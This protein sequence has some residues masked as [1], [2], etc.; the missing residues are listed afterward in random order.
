MFASLQRPVL[1][2]LH[3]LIVRGSWDY[4]L[5][6][7]LDLAHPDSVDFNADMIPHDLQIDEARSRLKVVSLDGPFVGTIHLPHDRVVQRE[8]SPA[9]PHFRTIDELDSLLVH[10]VVTNEDGGF[11]R[12]HGFNTDAVKASIAANLRAGA[13][14]RGAG[15]ITMQLV[16]NLY[17]GHERTL[18]RKAQ[19][20]TLTW[21]LEHLTYTSKRRLLEIYLNII[22][23]GPEVHGADEAAAYYF[24]TT[25]KKLTLAQ[26]L[27]LTTV[28]P[29]PT[30]WKYR[31]DRDGALRPFERAQM[32][33]IGR[34]MVSKGWL[35]ESEL[36]PADSLTVTLT[37]PARDVLFPRADA[38]ATPPDSIAAPRH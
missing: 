24:G 17:L 14:K 13:Y 4:R 35:T 9:N 15:T 32:H 25:A 5:E 7:Q 23:W 22:E 6:F 29:A 30:R 28:I 37:G 21:V 34:A 2:P 11:F 38:V 12:H 20:V 10:A 31:F 18:A 19:E 1:G 33:F 26:S 36:P 16:R 27:F 3:E 8:L